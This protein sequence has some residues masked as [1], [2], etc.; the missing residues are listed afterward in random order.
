MSKAW[1]ELQVY[2]DEWLNWRDDWLV[3]DSVADALNDFT[4]STGADGLPHGYRI[5]EIK[6]VLMGGQDGAV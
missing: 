2:E 1:F 4:E 3:Y 5:V 6:P